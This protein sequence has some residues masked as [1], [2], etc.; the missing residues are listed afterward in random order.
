MIFVGKKLSLCVIFLT[1]LSNL[2]KMFIVR[3]KITTPK[4]I[5]ALI[6]QQRKSAKL[7]IADLAAM[8]P[9]SP[10]L[11]GE[12]ERGT[13]NVSL[14]TVLTICGLLGVDL[15]ATTREGKGW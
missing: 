9:C 1:I 13:R 14:G 2:R 5:G 3:M 8:V 7:T 10:R 15:E 4:E 12:A 11:L 6:R